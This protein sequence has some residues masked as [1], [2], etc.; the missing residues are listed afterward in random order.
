MIISL[1]K[2]HITIWIILAIL[3]PVIF[4]VGLALRHGEPLNDKIPT[5]QREEAKR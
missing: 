4:F 3:L 2:R 5:V 1:R